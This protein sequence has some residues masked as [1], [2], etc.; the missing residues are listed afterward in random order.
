[1]ARDG[2]RGQVARAQMPPPPSTSVTGAGAGRVGH[3]TRRRRS[4]SVYSDS[5]WSAR[6]VIVAIV[7]A[8]RIGTISD[9]SSVISRSITEAM[10]GAWVV[11]AVAAAMPAT[12]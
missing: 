5:L 7:A 6:A 1:A 9:E 3:G 4:S 8:S 12:A 10:S 11:A 2:R